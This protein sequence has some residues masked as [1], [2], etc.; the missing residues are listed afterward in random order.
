MIV[1]ANAWLA[2]HVDVQVAAVR[3]LRI[4]CGGICSQVGQQLPT[5]VLDS[6]AW[7][8]MD[9]ALLALWGKALYATSIENPENLTDH[10]DW[11]DATQPLICVFL[12]AACATNKGIVLQYLSHPALVSLGPI[13]YATYCVQGQF[14]TSWAA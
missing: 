10:F 7:I 1:G 8:F 3:L 9:S 6:R 13:S 2:D 5:R 14:L 4:R 12:V 11:L